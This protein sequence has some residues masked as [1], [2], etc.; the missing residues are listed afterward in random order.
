MNYLISIILLLISLMILRKTS[1]KQIPAQAIPVM[2]LNSPYM[3][4]WKEQNNIKF[5]FTKCPNSLICFDQRISK[6]LIEALNKINQSA[7]F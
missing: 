5:I 2:G 4:I 7:T 6:N 1:N 3:W